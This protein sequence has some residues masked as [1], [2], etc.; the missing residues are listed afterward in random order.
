MIVADL[1]LSLKQ[2]RTDLDRS[3]KLSAPLHLDAV[4]QRCQSLLLSEDVP[5]PRDDG[6][7][8]LFAANPYRLLA[9]GYFSDG[10]LARPF[11]NSK[12]RW[13]FVLIGK[14]FFIDAKIHPD[15]RQ[16]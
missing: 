2:C 5:R 16:L 7:S 11:S 9:I 6:G 13:L 12:P 4:M 14:Q 10:A 1:G 15:F 8:L 3:I